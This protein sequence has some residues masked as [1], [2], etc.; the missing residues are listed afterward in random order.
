MRSDLRDSVLQTLLPEPEGLSAPEILG[1]L[2]R[3]I[4]QPTL[5]RTLDSLRSEGRVT[6]EGRARATRYRAAGFTDVGARR[7][8]LMHRAVARRVARDPGALAVA[9][10]RLVQLRRVNPHGLPYHDRWQL[11]LEGPIDVLLRALTEDSEQATAMRKESPFT[12]LVTP[13]E[14]KQAFGQAR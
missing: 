6:V 7:S 4:S 10:N 9:R 3:G 11:L 8:L 5:W 1:R 2:K 12:T 13:A 14:R